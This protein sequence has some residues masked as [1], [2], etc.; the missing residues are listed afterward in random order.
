MAICPFCN[1]TI[2][3]DSIEREKK[4][5]GFFKQEMMYSCPH[6]KKVLGFSRGKYTG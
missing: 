2:T 1:G 6:C 3:L 5:L 4:G